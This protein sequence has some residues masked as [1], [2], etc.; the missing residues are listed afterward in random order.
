[1]VFFAIWWAWMN[2]TWFASAYDTDDVP[3]RVMTFVQMAGVLLLAAGCFRIRRR[4]HHGHLRLPRHARRPGEPVG[5]RRD[6]P[7]RRA[8]HRA[9]LRGRRV[10]APGL[11]A[12]AAR[13]AG[14]RAVLG[15]PH[16]RA[17]R[18]VR[19]A[20]R[21]TSPRD[22]LAPA[23]HRRTVRPVH[24]H[25]AGRERPGRDERRPGHGRAR[26]A[27][28]TRRHRAGRSRHP[29]HALVDLLLRTR[30]EASPTAAT[31]PSPGATATT[32][33]SPRWPPWA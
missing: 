11:L 19:A 12:V 3:Y 7:P 33:S 30:G 20:D 6:R 22:D 14:R 23:S 24:D 9:P 16:P 17:A 15:V 27:R 1:M 5:A 32:W 10:A 4:L 25:P 28:G 31:G 8:R 13:P 2:F 18:T 21:G 29:V 26:P